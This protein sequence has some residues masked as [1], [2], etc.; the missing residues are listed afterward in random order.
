VAE[1]L[2]T[3]FYVFLSVILMAWIVGTITLLVVKSDEKTGQ[4]R[5]NLGNLDLFSHTH[6][7]PEVGAAHVQCNPLTCMHTMH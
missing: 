3:F 7:V 6:D 4:Y 5:E 1:A 2:F